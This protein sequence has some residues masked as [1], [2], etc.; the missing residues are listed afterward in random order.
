MRR[1]GKRRQEVTNKEALQRHTRDTEHHIHTRE[2]W[3]GKSADQSGNNWGDDTLTPFRCISGNGDYGGDTDDEA[4]LIG[5]DDT[6]VE[7][8]KTQFDFHRCLIVGVSED[9]EYKLRFI[10]GTGTMTAAITAGQYSENMVKFE[11]TNPQLSAGIPIDVLMSKIASGTKVWAQCKNQ[12]DNATI[13]FY[14]G[15]HEYDE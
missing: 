5:S 12:T 10:W 13:D 3:F 9:T 4:K 14:I 2:R 1:T 15:L 11:S 6:P 7:A 8:G